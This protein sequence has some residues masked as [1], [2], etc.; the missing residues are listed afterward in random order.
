M[1][2]WNST[3]EGMHAQG[4]SKISYAITPSDD[5][6]KFMLYV[7]NDDIYSLQSLVAA[8]RLVA[9]LEAEN[10]AQNNRKDRMDEIRDFLDIQGE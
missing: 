8:V 5:G 9:Q 6:T 3:P 7:G 2:K 10:V 1:L 4:E